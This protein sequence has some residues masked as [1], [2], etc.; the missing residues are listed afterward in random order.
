MR[1]RIQRCLVVEAGVSRSI[2]ERNHL[3]GSLGFEDV[4]VKRWKR[5]VAVGAVVM[6]HWDDD[7][8]VARGQGMAAD[9]CQ[10]VEWIRSRGDGVWGVVCSVCA[11]KGKIGKGK[12][13]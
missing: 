8:E 9:L 12:E 10:A 11:G 5:G 6:E 2:E 1:W 3:E 7:S 13:G 4:D